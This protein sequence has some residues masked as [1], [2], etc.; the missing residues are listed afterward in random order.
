[1]VFKNLSFD[2][3]VPDYVSEEQLLED[4]GEA[5][6]GSLAA[7]AANR[8]A[9]EAAWVRKRKGKDIDSAA[10]NPKKRHR[11]DAFKWLCMTDWQLL[12]NTGV[13]FGHFALTAGQRKQLPWHSLPLLSYAGDQGS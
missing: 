9:R 5:T 6:E 11:L 2:E 7:V 13:G 3:V 10:W 8:V 4:S 12:Q 1:M